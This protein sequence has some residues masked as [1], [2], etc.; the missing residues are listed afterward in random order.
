LN[1]VDWT[2]KRVLEKI[3]KTKG[4]SLSETEKKRLEKQIR[5]VVKDSYEDFISE[6]PDASIMDWCS[7]YFKVTS[8]MVDLMTGNLEEVK[9][10]CN[11]LLGLGSSVRWGKGGEFVG[12][13]ESRG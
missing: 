13:E 11:F 8:A 9:Q 4:E 2:V 3:E 12:E 6:Y 5:I 7:L 10:A 1:Y